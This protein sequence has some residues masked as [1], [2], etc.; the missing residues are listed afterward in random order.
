MRLRYDKFA[1]RPTGYTVWLSSR[2]TYEWAHRAGAAW[3]NSVLSDHR[4]MVEVDSNGLCGVAV[5][6][7]GVPRDDIGCQLAAMV[8]DH[9]P[10]A[11]RHLWPCWESESK[12]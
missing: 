6:G 7:D 12:E 10:A 9:L 2:E 3:P 5:D 11:L 1:K 4:V 8:A